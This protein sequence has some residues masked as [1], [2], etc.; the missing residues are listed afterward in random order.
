[1]QTFYF[2]MR[3]G[4]PIRDRVGKQFRSNSEAIAYGKA[5]A[6]RF[7][8]EHH[9]ESDLAI[10]AVDESGREVHREPVFLKAFA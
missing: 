2:D 5:L 3:D 8:H 6:E 1:M 7:R 4:V 10:V 9:V